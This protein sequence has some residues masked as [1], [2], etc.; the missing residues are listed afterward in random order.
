MNK[1]KTSASFFRKMFYLLLLVIVLFTAAEIITSI[2]Y[3][4]QYGQ[5]K[6]ALVELVYSVKLKARLKKESAAN[7]EKNYIS[8]HLVRPDS[9]KQMT[10]Q[11]YDETMASNHFIYEPWVEFRNADFKGTYVNTKGFIRKS[12][13][14]FVLKRS[15]TITIWF[16]GGSTMFGFNVAD[17][18]TIP[19]QLAK[20]YKDSSMGA[21]SL[22][23]INFGIPYYFSYQEYQLFRLLLEKNPAPDYAVFF[24]GLNEFWSYH[25]TYYQQPY[26]SDR[27]SSMMQKNVFEFLPSSPGNIYRLQDSTLSELQCDTLINKYLNSIT[28]IEKQ[29]AAAGVKPL[30]VVQPVPFYNYKNQM[31]DPICTKKQYRF[32][33]YI[34]PRLEQEFLNKTNRLYSGNLN[35]SAP[36]L[37]YIDAVHYSPLFNKQIAS[38]ILHNL[39]K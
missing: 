5:R 23:V 35:V 24:D 8:Q 34:Y 22:R 38:V 29:A 28:L 30:F 27:L 33:N 1:P 17:F 13:P 37:P 32:F 12:I 21:S 6:L 14:D 4:H 2:F 25:N 9:S 39:L 19:S 11:V 3:Y 15:D 10:Q 36:A 26:F 18:E 20:L 7:K 16:F 31:T